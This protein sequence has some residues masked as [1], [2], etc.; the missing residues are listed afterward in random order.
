M[1]RRHARLETIRGD[2][3]RTTCPGMSAG[4]STRNWA[5]SSK[6]TTLEAA[7]EIA[8]PT[9][10]H[11]LLV[12]TFSNCIW[13]PG[14]LLGSRRIGSCRV[15][16]GCNTVAQHQTQREYGR[17]ASCARGAVLAL[18]PLRSSDTRGSTTKRPARNRWSR[19]FP[20]V[21]NLAGG[22][23]SAATTRSVACRRV[24]CSGAYD[25]IL[26]ASSRPTSTSTATEL[27]REAPSEVVRRYLADGVAPGLGTNYWLEETAEAG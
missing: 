25:V 26:A 19:S 5:H 15:N 12:R 8:R 22:T 24:V 21:A 27:D 4:T 1:A 3:C 10:L 17:S 7:A 6:R 9:S 20:P 18:T 16:P 13:L 23:G 11:R 2:A 14:C